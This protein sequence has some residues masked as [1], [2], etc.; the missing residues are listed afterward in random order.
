M[1]VLD[2]QMNKLHVHNQQYIIS[3]WVKCQNEFSLFCNVENVCSSNAVGDHGMEKIL[4]LFTV[5]LLSIY[6]VLSL[7]WIMERIF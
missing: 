4:I 6:Y 1:W 2:I 5:Y 3:N 7:R